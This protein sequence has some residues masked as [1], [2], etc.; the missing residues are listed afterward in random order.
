MRNGGPNR[1]KMVEVFACA[2]LLVCRSNI[3]SQTSKFRDSLFPCAGVLVRQEMAGSKVHETWAFSTF[4]SFYAPF[5]LSSGNDYTG[6]DY[7]ELCLQLLRHLQWFEGSSELI[8]GSNSLSLSPFLPRLSPR[9]GFINI[10][11]F[12]VSFANFNG[13]TNISFFS[14][15]IRNLSDKSIFIYS[16]IFVLV[17]YIK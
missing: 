3:L 13:N 12:L 17:S 10:C 16:P 4:E 5:D 1:H 9:K 6:Q 14:Y 8:K 11:G 2:T 7:C 15:F